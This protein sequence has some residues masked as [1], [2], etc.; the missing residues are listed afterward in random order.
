MVLDSYLYVIILAAAILVG[1]ILAFALKRRGRRAKAHPFRSLSP[2][3]TS[4]VFQEVD[5]RAVVTHSVG[6]EDSLVLTLR[7]NLLLKALG[8]ASVVE[9]LVAFERSKNPAG[10]Q[11]QWLDAA[12]RRWEHDNDRR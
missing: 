2:R 1:L 12:I 11:A 6:S 8:N 9:R 10:D 3:S 4:T 5:T 7:Q